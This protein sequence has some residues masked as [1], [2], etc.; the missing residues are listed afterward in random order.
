M[1]TRNTSSFRFQ[2]ETK[3]FH[4]KST[5]AIFN[6]KTNLLTLFQHGEKLFTW[7]RNANLY[8]E[9]APLKERIEIPT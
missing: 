9:K 6:A 1:F 8:Q 2:Y 5:A 7:P 3:L 4:R